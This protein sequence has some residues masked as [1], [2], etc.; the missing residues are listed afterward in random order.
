VTLEQKLAAGTEVRLDKREAQ[1]VLQKL[2]ARGAESKA[3]DAI[4]AQLQHG[5]EVVLAPA[6][7][8]A[9]LE[10]L[11]ASGRRWLSGTDEPRAHEPPRAAPSE[12]EPEPEPAPS[13]WFS[14]LFRR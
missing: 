1:D 13:G 14:R 4:E 7:A 11:K 5:D 6:Q 12:P 8:G 9:L 10:E 2:R 3:A